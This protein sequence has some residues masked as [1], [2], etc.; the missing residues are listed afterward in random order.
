MGIRA[1]SPSTSLTIFDQS[2]TVPVGEKVR[3]PI[4]SGSFPQKLGERKSAQD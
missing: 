4:V 2:Q 3:D 1:S